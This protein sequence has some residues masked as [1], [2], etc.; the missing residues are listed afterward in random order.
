MNFS[1]DYTPEQEKF[2]KEVREWLDANIPKGLEVVRDPIKMSPEQWQL[3]RDFVR[4]AGK[5]GW[6]YPGYPKEYGGGGLDAEH[7]YVLTNEFADRGLGI[8][9][10]YDVGVLAGP[11]ILLAGT[12][13]QKK[14]FLPPI[15]TGEKITWQLFTEPEAGTDEANQQTNAIR[16]KTEPEYFVVNGQKIFVGSAPTKPEQLFLLTRSDLEAPRHKN[17]AMFLI[18][19][20][21]PGITIEPLDLFPMGTFY[22]AC[23]PTGAN[24]EGTK[25]SI[26]FDDVKIHEKYLVGG[27]HDGWK[28]VGATL[29]VEHSG[30]FVGV[31]G[32]NFMIEKFLPRCK[33][34]PI[35]QKRFKENPQLLDNL[36][37][38]YIDSNI[39]KLFSI[40]NSWAAFNHQHIPHGGQQLALWSKMWGGRAGED[41]L[42]ILGPYAISDDAEY[43]LDDTIYEVCQR[44]GV[45]YAS[46]GTPEALKIGISRALSIGR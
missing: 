34:D 35:L 40:R 17:L 32:R 5:K 10:L 36:V 23:C 30:N 31:I 43:G 44:S 13:E 45:C 24:A 11:A 33:K 14:T 1:L 28:V 19:P 15:F 21:L 41:L 46:G 39:E 29:D 38:L 4:V 9:I 16:S 3:R 12:E 20:D 7:C 42:S 25:H 27:D 8:P 2:A 37:N 6:L 22:E 18:P 26:F